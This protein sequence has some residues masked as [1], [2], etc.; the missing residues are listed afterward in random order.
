[1]RDVLKL[2][3]PSLPGGYMQ[4]NPTLC[5]CMYGDTYIDILF[6]TFI[7]A[8][9]YSYVYL[10]I[11]CLIYLVIYLLFTYLFICLFIY[12]FIYLLIYV[13]V[14]AHTSSF[15]CWLSIYFLCNEYMCNTS[16]RINYPSKAPP[17]FPRATSR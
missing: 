12:L 11:Y 10:F 1:M 15:V 13:Y 4:K 7:F 8:F 3:P 6:F 5:I 16:S 14:R 9:I 2:L 17:G